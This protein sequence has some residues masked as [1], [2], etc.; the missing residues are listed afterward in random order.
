M[1]RKFTQTAALLV[2]AAAMFF[3]SCK[4][5]NVASRFNSKYISANSGKLNATVPE[6]FELGYTMLALTDLAQKDTSIINQNTAYYRE[7]MAWFNKYKDNKGVKQL[8]ADLS[9]NPKLVKS[10]LD[11]LYAFQLNDGRFAL[12]SSYRIDL[13]KVDFKRYAILL[14][15]FYKATNFHEFY[16]QHADLY[17]QMVQKANSTYTYEEAQKTVNGAVKGYQVVLS[18]LTKVY[19]GTMEIKG[20]AYS[21]CIIFPRLAVEGR[22]Y[23]MKEA[24]K[25]PKS[26]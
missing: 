24:I 18:P 9:R 25:G 15:K 22:S 12:K 11:G 5:Y 26:E 17:T 13:N 19:A 21:E 14:E 20:H 4:S 1:T 7:L 3:T 8:N 10:Y 23:A 2:S 6:N 16:A